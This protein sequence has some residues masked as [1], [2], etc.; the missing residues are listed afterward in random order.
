[1][2][3]ADLEQRQ[4]KLIEARECVPFSGLVTN[5]LVQS[6]SLQL[7]GWLDSARQVDRR[8]Y[9]TDQSSWVKKY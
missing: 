6:R 2:T 1:V 9:I 5:I 7:A 4:L 8:T 3:V